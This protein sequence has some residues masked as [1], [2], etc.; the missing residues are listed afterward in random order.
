MNNLVGDVFLG[1]IELSI[2]I[3]ASPEKIWEM[4]TIDR[5]PEWEE[6]YK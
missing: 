3:K 5:F 6:G 1:S 4:L 2:E